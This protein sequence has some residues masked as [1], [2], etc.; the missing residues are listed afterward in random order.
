MEKLGRNYLHSN[1]EELENLAK[2]R[3]S[4]VLLVMESIKEE[5]EGHKNPGNF[6]NFENYESELQVERRPPNSLL[7]MAGQRMAR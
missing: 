4:S 3:K 7:S 5:D 1:S 6:D 2:A